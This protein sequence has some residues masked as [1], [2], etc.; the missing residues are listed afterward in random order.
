MI[1]AE[2]HVEIGW[3]A[4]A[5]NNLSGDIYIVLNSIELHNFVTSFSHID[6]LFLLLDI[7]WSAAPKPRYV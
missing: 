2:F 6:S 1:R 4:Q 7:V 5:S 3:I